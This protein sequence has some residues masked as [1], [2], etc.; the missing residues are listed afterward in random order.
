MVTEQ[1]REAIRKSGLSQSDL[2]ARSGV[3]QPMISKLMRGGGVQSRTLDRLAQT[4]GLVLE[5]KTQR[6]RKA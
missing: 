6:I 2:S 4:L 1:L 3:T 5:R